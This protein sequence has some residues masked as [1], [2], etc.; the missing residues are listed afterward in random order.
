MTLQTQDE[1]E[2]ELIALRVAPPLTRPGVVQRAAAVAE[3]AAAWIRAHS[4]PILVYAGT[5]IVLMLVAWLDVIITRHPLA[6][7][8][9]LFD[10]RWYLA[11]L[12][13]GYPD[14]AVHGKSTLGFLPAYPLAIR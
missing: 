5:R 2:R 1:M 11:V 14:Y 8:L 7:E 13:A 6:G 9:S 10:G 12:N 4:W 3:P